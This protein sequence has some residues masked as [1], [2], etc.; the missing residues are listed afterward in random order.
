MRKEI[1]NEKETVITTPEGE[2][3]FRNDTRT[4]RIYTKT[5]NFYQVFLENEVLVWKNVK[6]LQARNLLSYLCNKA[7]RD[8]GIVCLSKMELRELET[9]FGKSFI[10]NIKKIYRELLKSEM[11]FIVDEKYNIYKINPY[12]F[13]N[14]TNTSRIEAIEVITETRIILKEEKEE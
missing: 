9:L 1:V 12:I 14:G 7:K 2:I 13:W 6:S 4:Y 11:I 3:T 10:H 8:T 5:D